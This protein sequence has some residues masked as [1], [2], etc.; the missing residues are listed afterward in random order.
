MKVRYGWLIGG[1]VLALVAGGAA[2]AVLQQAGVAPRV[3]ARYVERRA[4]GHNPVIV[5][6]AAFAARSAERVDRGEGGA[7][8]PE[9]L[10]I[11]AQAEAV[12]ADAAAAGREIMVDSVEQLAAAAA[13]AEAGD[14]LTILPGHYRLT[15]GIGLT[16]AG[17]SARPIV[18]RAREP[19]SVV[20]EADTVQAFVVG[21]SDWRVENLTIRGVCTDHGDC[22]HAFHVVA[23]GS[24]FTALN[25]TISDF[26]A[27]FKVNGEDGRFPD[28]GRIEG[29]TLDNSGVRRVASAVTAIDMVAVSGWTVRRNVIRDFIKGGGDQVSYG[30][31]AKGAGTHNLFEQNVVLCE[32]KLHGLPGARV[33]LSLGGGGSG[34]PF[35]RDRRCIT[36][37]ED[38]TLR[39][40]LIASCSDAGI[41]LNSAA[42]STVS[43]N[44]LLDTAGIDVRF[45]ASSARLDGNLV[46]GAIRS[47]NDGV[48]YMGQNQATPTGALYLGWHPVR[49][50]F[51]RVD[52]LALGWAGAPPRRSGAAGDVRSDLC[53]VQR[54]APAALGAFERFDACLRP[55]VSP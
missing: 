39:A 2:L 6:A 30:A 50:L 5:G 37:Q 9:G 27:H 31:Y 20:I 46:D 49:H 8:L 4:E 18:L 15:R 32:S 48:I 7:V 52:T 33:G 41:Y 11:G 51:A 16:R 42:R 53:G 55:A 19:G 13:A 14:V 1:A 17:T 21:G 28:G 47:R 34:A 44:T 25:N 35:C 3:L 23:G 24:R 22:E 29:N 38:S 10:R 45:A 40:N 36:E 26:N 12:G 43:D 54:A